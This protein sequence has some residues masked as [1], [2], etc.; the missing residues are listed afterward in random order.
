MCGNVPLYTGGML[1]IGYPQGNETREKGRKPRDTGGSLVTNEKRG[2]VENR[3]DWLVPPGV[4]CTSHGL[5]ASGKRH[6]G[7]KPTP[8]H[9][10]RD[11]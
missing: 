7:A 1:H 3:H 2:G 5:D 6:S 8:P 10:L 4:Q 9:F 11:R